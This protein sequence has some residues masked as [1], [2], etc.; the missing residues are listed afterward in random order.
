MPRPESP[1]TK[2]CTLDRAG[3]CI[4]CLRTGS[5]IASWLSMTSAEQWQLLAVLAQRRRLRASQF[6][7]G[8]T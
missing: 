4:G 6:E 1:C 2:I 5:E 3:L 8:A 7:P